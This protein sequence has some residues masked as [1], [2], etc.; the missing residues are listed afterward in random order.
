MKTVQKILKETQDFCKDNGINFLKCKAIPP[1]LNIWVDDEVSCDSFLKIALDESKKVIFYSLNDFSFFD[2]TGLD[3]EEGIPSEYQEFRDYDGLPVL[4]RLTI[5]LGSFAVRFELYEPWFK[6][7]LK[8]TE[9]VEEK[10]IEEN[11]DM[12]GDIN[13]C[14]RLLA[15]HPKYYNYSTRRDQ[16]IKLAKSIIEQA[17]KQITSDY[18]LYSM[19][20]KADEIFNEKFLGAAEGKLKESIRALVT[21]GKTK[22]AIASIL[23]VT[24][25]MVAKFY[26]KK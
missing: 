20:P 10:I 22:K 24:E 7:F 11:K 4:I 25:G 2:E 13:K 19:L 15:E 1:I 26:Y 23:D 8:L 6:D 21:E 5:P 9:E 14:A 16:K 17:N 12:W 3:P 18:I